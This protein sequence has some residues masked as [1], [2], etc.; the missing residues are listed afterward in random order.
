MLGLGT[1]APMFFVKFFRSLIL[2]VINLQ[3]TL[4]ILAELARVYASHFR[5]LLVVLI[6][7]FN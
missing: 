1:R 2:C 5:H 6:S 7:L 4:V 3:C